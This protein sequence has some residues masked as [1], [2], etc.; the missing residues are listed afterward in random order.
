MVW[1]STSI[2]APDG[3]AAPDLAVAPNGV[4][5]V[6]WAQTDV[7][8]EQPLIWSTSRSAGDAS[9]S[10]PAVLSGTNES[11]DPSVAINASGGAVVA[12][13]EASDAGSRPQRDD[14]AAGSGVEAAVRRHRAPVVGFPRQDRLDDRRLRDGDPLLDEGYHTID[15]VPVVE[16]A[17]AA[18]DGPWS[19]ATAVGQ[20]GQF[21]NHVPA[22]ISVDAGGNVALARLSPGVGP[23]LARPAAAGGWSGPTTLDN[24]SGYYLMPAVTSAPGGDAV[25]VWGGK[26]AISSQTGT[27][28]SPL[29]ARRRG[30][31]G[32]VRGR[33]VHGD[34]RPGGRVLR[35]RVR[36]VVRRRRRDL[37]ASATARAP[38][39]PRCRTPTQPLVPTP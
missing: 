37:E 11:Q 32:A 22:H 26:A 28:Q 29:D 19:E 14:A 7:E 8:L 23:V 20:I 10:S 12:W 33:P 13:R 25:V 16:S 9:F 34:S 18:W 5:V 6:V 2:S 30:P 21:T 3:I 15:D 4:A 1:S 36:R 27:A 39:G 17:S 31:G 35:Q 38:R 24:R